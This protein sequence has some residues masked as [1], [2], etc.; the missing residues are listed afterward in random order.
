LWFNYERSAAV[1]HT[2]YIAKSRRVAS[3]HN[4]K[5]VSVEALRAGEARRD[6]DAASVICI[7]PFIADAD[8]LGPVREEFAVVA[9]VRN[10]VEYQAGGR[11]G[12]QV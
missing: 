6:Q 4:C 12:A 11:S 2:E 7:A 9:S 3:L 10:P 5:P 8:R 1:D